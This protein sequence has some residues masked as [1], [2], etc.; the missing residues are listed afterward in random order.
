MP[1]LPRLSS[2]WRN[3]LRKTR[4]EQDLKEEV[5][6]YLE[7]LIE[8]KIE[9]GIPPAEARRQ[10][11]IE[12]GGVE[13]VKEQVRE[14]RMGHHLEILW[15]DVRYGMRLLLK[16]PGFTAVAV[17][18]L[19]LGIGAN[20]AIFSL[21]DPIVIKLLPVKDPERLVVLETVDQRGD[22]RERFSYP[23][24]EQLR[25]RTQVFSGIFATNYPDRVEMIG[26]EPGN[27]TEEARLQLVS[28]EYFQVL[29]VKAVLGRTLTTADDQTP[30]AHPMAVLSYPFWQRRFAGDASV[31]GQDITL[32]NQPFTIIG[33]TAP[34][35]FGTILGKE[36]D[37]W[38]PLMMDTIYGRG[39]SDLRIV[40]RDW[41][42]IM[43]RRQPGVRE[44]QAQAA[45]DIFLG[46]IKSEPSDLGKH[47]WM[48]KILLSSG[49]QGFKGWLGVRVSQPLL[50]LMAVVG[51]ALLI[52]CANVANLLLARA[53]GRQKEVAI[54]LTIG[55]GRF[56]LVRQFLTESALLAVA[57][58]AL[59][60]LFAWWGCDLI[61]ALISEYDS[62][63]TLGSIGAIPNARVLGFTI[64]V[65]L[66]ATLLFGL[67]PALIATRQ[68]V[69]TALNAP[70]PPRSRLSLS[71]SLVI[72]QVALSL[73]LLTGAGLFV[74]T[75]HNLRTRDFG[76]AT[77]QIIQGW[78]VAEESG[79]KAE[80]RPDLYR[81]ILERLNSAPGI[82]SA[83]MA[84]AGFLF[85]V[86]DGSCCIAVE[87]YTYQPDE[88]RRIR[89]N[90]VRPGYFQTIGLPL[91]LG[92]DFTQQEIRSEPEKFAKVAIINETMARR[93][94]GTANP[95][96]K[97]FG[98]DDPR[99]GKGYPQWL[100]RFERGDPRQ[101]E[102]IGV[103]KDAVH[104][105]IRSETLP[106]IY[107]P[108]QDG[109]TLVARAAGPAA[110]LAA[111]ILREIQAVDKNLVIADIRTSSQ[112]IDQELFLERLLA[113]LSS[114]FAL[115]AL[116]LASIGL[117]GVMSYDVE[118]RT[119]EIGIRMALGAQRRDVIGLVLRE[120]MLLVV[121]GV[122]IG[123]S[124][125]IGATRL[126]TSLLYGLTPND[127]L[128]IT[129]ASL[130]LLTVAA[131]AGYLPARR[132]ARVDPMVALK[133]E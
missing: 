91:L 58:A 18:S 113:K 7:M 130:L 128:T 71:R 60:L 5:D 49:R 68:D 94:F 103:A 95:L 55:A 13:Q 86:T 21:V 114:F 20:T 133:H 45:L 11:L 123:L 53:A 17:L 121:I 118:R 15:R 66:F 48:S 79:Y 87:G 57:G 27:R 104:N 111:T 34:E 107:F 115:L 12:M 51:L 23:L 52:A 24:F 39:A 44:E 122:I 61:L 127:P 83:T 117:Y 63:I 108:S 100:P 72:A 46:Q 90:G 38:A 3:L 96:G 32:N 4:A 105:R 74:R 25:A 132:A 54:R 119:H 98:W 26:P 129:L 33:V 8:I 29:G 10:A 75:L 85:G 80:Q 89:T 19:A 67:A 125:A 16:S 65:S 92:R 59:G 35:F 88:E 64:V 47:A 78:I 69:N 14:V 42:R 120:T 124:A 9:Q 28:G 76:F 6:A 36:P 50:I 70:A 84:E 30:G 31:M 110:P 93:Y 56:R 62:S 37:I 112:L 73:L 81:R 2:L 126:I 116:L 97:R 41:L 106:L 109:D 22:V 1:L 77:E 131:L 102:I 43:A 101:F 82:R 99:I 40:N